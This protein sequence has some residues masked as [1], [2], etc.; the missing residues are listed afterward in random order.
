MC[1]G[2]VYKCSTDLL[3]DFDMNVY[4]VSETDEIL[5]V[6]IELISMIER[7]IQLLLRTSDGRATGRLS[8]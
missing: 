5:S 1:K 6:D 3:I 4:E 2:C 7:E 8:V